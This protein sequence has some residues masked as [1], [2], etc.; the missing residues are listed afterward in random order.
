VYTM[1]GDIAKRFKSTWIWPLPP[2][3]GNAF[4]DEQSKKVE[5]NVN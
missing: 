1:T 4:Q 2:A 5:F 3:L